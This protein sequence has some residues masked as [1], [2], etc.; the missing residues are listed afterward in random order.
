MTEICKWP[1]SYDQSKV[2]DEALD[3]VVGA[4]IDERQQGELQPQLWGFFATCFTGGAKTISNQAAQLNGLDAWRRAVRQ[5][6]NG[7]EIRL[8]ELRREMRVIHFKP[9]RGLDA[10][11]AGVAEFE[12]KVREFQG[13]G[14]GACPAIPA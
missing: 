2:T 14:D 12:E 8:G 5:V 3:L 11:H 10:V 6:D 13:A 7:M 9:V 4:L 1:E